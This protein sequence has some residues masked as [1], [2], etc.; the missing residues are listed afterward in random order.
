MAALSLSQGPHHY[1]PD[2]GADSLYAPAWGDCNLP[3][4]T[5]Q[6]YAC[7][8][9]IYYRPDW[10]VP[11]RWPCRTFEVAS[12]GRLHTGKKFQISS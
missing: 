5:Y 7:G 10:S 1:C 12:A 3:G 2:C 4:Y 6:T 11:F 9:I 8:A